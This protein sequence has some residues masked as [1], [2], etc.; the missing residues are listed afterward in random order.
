MDNVRRIRENKCNCDPKEVRCKV[1]R[2]TSVANYTRMAAHLYPPPAAT[3]SSPPSVEESAVLGQS[4]SSSFSSP[5]EPVPSPSLGKSSQS[6][7]P[8]PAKKP[9]HQ[10]GITQFVDHTFTEDEQ[11]SSEKAQALAAVM[12]GWSFNSLEQPWTHAW[13][14]SLRIDY[15]PPST[16]KLEKQLDSGA[17]LPRGTQ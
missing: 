4:S 8:P 16:Y 11:L 1:C 7:L 3:S 12:N 9:K 15:R 10:L 5:T 17:E 2:W 6:S 13:L 14:S